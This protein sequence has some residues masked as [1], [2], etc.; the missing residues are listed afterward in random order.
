MPETCL[1]D[2][3]RSLGF[4][5]WKLLRE[6]WLITSHSMWVLHHCNFPFSFSSAS[7]TCTGSC[8]WV[9]RVSRIG[10]QTVVTIGGCSKMGAIKLKIKPVNSSNFHIIHSNISSTS[11]LESALLAHAGTPS[12]ANSLHKTHHSI[13]TLNHCSLLRLLHESWCWLKVSGTLNSTQ[14]KRIPNLGIPNHNYE[15]LE[16][17]TDLGFHFEMA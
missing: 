8:H 10:F 5:P 1:P 13:I 17:G 11:P 14:T 15:H 4:S 16:R 6:T 3:T 12:P 9:R 2:Q 7:S